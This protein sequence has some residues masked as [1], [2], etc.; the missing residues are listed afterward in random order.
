ML[1]GYYKVLFFLS[2][3]YITAVHFLV[4]AE[5]FGFLNRQM[6]LRRVVCVAGQVCLCRAQ[7]SVLHY[8]NTVWVRTPCSLELRKPCTVL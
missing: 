5:Y 6:C 3:R 2:L 7:T 1:C 4:E 8:R